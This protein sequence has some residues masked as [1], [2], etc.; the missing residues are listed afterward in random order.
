MKKTVIVYLLGL[1]L[2]V[3]LLDRSACADVAADLSQAD[4]LY[5]T[6]QYAQAEQ[7][8]LKVIRGTDANKPAESDAAFAAAKGL[9]LVYIATDRLPQAEQAIQPLLARPTPH[10]LHKIVEEAKALKKLPQVRQVYQDM[11]AARPDDHNV[12]WLKT[13]LGVASAHLGDDRVVQATLDNIIANHG[14]DD[15]VVEALGQIAWAYRKLNQYDKALKINQYTVDNWPQ[16]DRA[17]YAQQGVLLC[18]IGLGNIAAADQAFGVLIQQFGKDPDASKIV[19]WSGFGYQDANQADRA[20]KVYELVVQN[21][22]DTPEAVTAQ[23]RLALASVEAED[24]N[25]MGQT[26]QALL[27]QF[28]PTQDKGAALRYLADSLYWKHAAYV[29]QAV[30]HQNT[31]ALTDQYARAIANYTLANWPNSDWAVWAERDMANGAIRRGD[32]AAAVDVLNG[33]LTRYA[34]LESLPRAVCQIGDTFLDVGKSDQADQLFRYAIEN[35]AGSKDV[36]WAKAGKVRVGIAKGDNATAE[37][38]F[39]QLLSD[40]A[41]DS[42]LP[43]IVNPIAEA[44]Y[45]GATREIRSGDIRP[46]A[47]RAGN[48]PPIHAQQCLRKAVDAWALFQQR[49]PKDPVVGPLSYYFSAICYA[50]LGETLNAVEAYHN[51]L[52]KWPDYEKNQ[53]AILTLVSLC[54]KLVRDGSTTESDIDPLLRW[55]YRQFTEKYPSHPAAA[56]VRQWLQLHPQLAEVDNNEK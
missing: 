30:Q 2:P 42:R 8:Y 28:T 19:L 32:D 53:N 26:I 52:E 27:T 7:P 21:Y 12:I 44:Y 14:Q 15:R 11:I 55:A 4:G 9:A 37:A 22:P 31:L 20:Y 17:A 23:L 16:K 5:K 39:K 43:D 1:L 33:M 49:W 29:N 35:W 18:Q 56:S 50:R 13:G 46:S 54:H 34:K 10:D 47:T 45:E 48:S 36:I 6:G 40:Y 25:R 51:L 41:D 38:R 24:P 3:V